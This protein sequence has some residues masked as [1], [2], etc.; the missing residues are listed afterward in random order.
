MSK[1]KEILLHY[2]NSGRIQEAKILKELIKKL[3]L[4]YVKHGKIK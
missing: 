2:Y 4:D 3:E 1:R